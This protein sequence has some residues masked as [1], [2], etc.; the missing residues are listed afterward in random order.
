MTHNQK[1]ET[2]REIRLWI[3]QIIVPACGVATAALTIPEVREMV[4]A[5]ADSIKESIKLKSRNK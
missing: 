5:K 3:G 4:A 1:I 2:M